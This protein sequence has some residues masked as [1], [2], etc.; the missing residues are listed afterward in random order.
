MKTI[1][2]FLLVLTGVFAIVGVLFLINRNDSL[3]T[4]VRSFD[5]RK[6]INTELEEPVAETVA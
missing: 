6:T 4:K 5:W 1:F 3:S 2:P